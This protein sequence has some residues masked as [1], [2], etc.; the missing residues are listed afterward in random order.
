MVELQEK[1]I[2]IKGNPGSSVYVSHTYLQVI[3]DIPYFV[4]TAWFLMLS[5]PCLFFLLLLLAGLATAADLYKSL[6][7]QFKRDFS[8]HSIDFE[9]FQSVQACF[10]TGH[11]KSLQEAE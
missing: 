6:E 1:E 8:R 10:G 5:A 4:P 2:P 7:R 9:L 11:Q 3:P